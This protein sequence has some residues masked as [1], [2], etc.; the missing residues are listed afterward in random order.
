MGMGEESPTSERRV[1]IGFGDSGS[2][3]AGASHMT[4]FTS[5]VDVIACKIFLAVTFKPHC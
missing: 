2:G 4:G 5:F 1:L 3:I